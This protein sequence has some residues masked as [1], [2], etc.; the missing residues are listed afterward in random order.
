M[1]NQAAVCILFWGLEETPGAKHFSES[2]QE[3]GKNSQH[4]SDL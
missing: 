4:T 3:S 2:G 1:V